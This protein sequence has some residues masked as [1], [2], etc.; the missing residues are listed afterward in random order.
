M[1]GDLVAVV[2]EPVE[3]EPGVKYTFLRF[4]Y[5]GQAEVGEDPLSHEISYTRVGRTTPGDIVVSNINAVN[6]AI[7][8]IPHDLGGLLISNEYTVLRPRPGVDADTLYLWSVLRSP[9]VT[10]EWIST[11]SGVGRHRLG[12]PVCS[13]RPLATSV[14]AASHRESL[15]RS[16]GA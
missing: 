1:R 11:A 3:I 10:A 13:A 14:R 2:D 12:L 16:N 5:E 15:P 6:K 4:T 8:V 7:C 9:A